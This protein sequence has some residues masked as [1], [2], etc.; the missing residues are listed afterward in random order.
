ME[1]YEFNLLLPTGTMH[2]ILEQRTGLKGATLDGV[3]RET[4]SRGNSNIQCYYSD[5]IIP[6]EE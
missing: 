3:A 4:D 1:K 6:R 5:S 2:T